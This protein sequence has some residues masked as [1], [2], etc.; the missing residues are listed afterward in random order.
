[1]TLCRNR[2]ANDMVLLVFVLLYSIFAVVDIFKSI[3][4]SDPSL[5][6]L[7]LTAFLGNSVCG[8]NVFKGLVTLDRSS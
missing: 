1:M 7:V 2:L 5:T 3:T 8:T 6:A 4:V